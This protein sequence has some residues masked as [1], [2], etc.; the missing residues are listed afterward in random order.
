LVTLTNRHLIISKEIVEC[1]FEDSS[2]VNWVFYPA[3]KILM[4][5]SQEDKNFKELHKTSLS[6]LKFK[7]SRGDRSISLEEL[8][9]DKEIDSN[10]RSLEYTA[11][12]KMKILTVYLQ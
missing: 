2:Q 1:T 7:N 8:L 11:D 3:K 12:E 4:V 5:A 9:I 10:D 6:M